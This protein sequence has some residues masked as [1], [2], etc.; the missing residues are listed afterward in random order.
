MRRGGRSSPPRGHPG[1]YS[2][3]RALA[4]SQREP[5]RKGRRDAPERPRG[6]PQPQLP[7]CLAVG[8][9]RVRPGVRR[10]AAA[11]RAR[12]TR[13]PRAGPAIAPGPD[14]L[15]S[16]ATV[17]GARVGAERTAGAPLCTVGAGAVSAESPG[18]PGRPLAGRTP[19]SGR[20]AS[21]SSSRPDACRPGPCDAT[22]RRFSRSRRID[23]T[24]PASTRSGPGRGDPE[25]GRG[26][27]G[28]KGS[29]R[30]RR[31]RKR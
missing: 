29:A 9:A 6:R 28:A 14:D 26:S 22:P 11:L 2:P 27:S 15:V 21:S 23:Q 30:V 19:A 13:G 4:R 31:T 24:V 25:L 17:G 10:P 18:L 7:G 1:G 5:R 8:W 12:G 16:P 20:R 3:G